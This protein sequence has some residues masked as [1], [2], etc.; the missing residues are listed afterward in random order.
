MTE[1]GIVNMKA[2]SSSNVV[3]ITA[4]LNDL[5]TIVVVTSPIPSHPDTCLIDNTLSRL[6]YHFPT[7]RMVVN[8]DGV[9]P[10]LA[11]RKHAYDDYL[12]RLQLLGRTGLDFETVTWFN[13]THQSTMFY[14]TL[15]AVTTPLVLFSE[16]DLPLFT[17]R[18]IDWHMIARAILSGAID[19]VRFMLTESIHPEHL[20]LYDG[21]HP[22]YPDLFR[23]RQYSGW[24]HIASTDMYRRLF[25]GYDRRA[26]LMLEHYLPRIIEPHPER[27]RMASYIP[28]IIAAQRIYHT[29]GR[30]GDPWLEGNRVYPI[31]P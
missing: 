4:E 10:E 28:N 3:E 2:N 26:R 15:E 7:A 25:A 19:L 13:H 27:C 18:E 22:E 20:Y 14:Q 6:R 21:P 24:T 8:C 11:H 1:S 16:H 30:S 23:Q 12:Y 29:D 9:R 17:D 31:T 5:V